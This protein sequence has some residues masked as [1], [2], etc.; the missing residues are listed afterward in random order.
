MKP[1]IRICVDR[2]GTFTDLI[3]FV[4]NSYN[5]KQPADGFHTIV[6]KLL[7][8]DS[9]YNDAPSEGIRRILELAL[10][11]KIPRNEPIPT[12]DIELI[13]MGTTV[14]TNALLERKGEKTLLL[15]TKGFQD[16]L[17]IGNQSRPNIF[18]L[19]VETMQVLYERVLE[20]DER[21]TPV[22]YTFNPKSMQVDVQ[23]ESKEY[24]KGITGQWLK[25]LQ[26]PDLNKLKIELL[27]A[28]K[29]GFES[30]AITFLHSYTLPI[31][32]EMVA[33]LCQQVGFK[34]ITMSSKTS[35][36]AKIVPRGT[37]TTADAYLTPVIQTYLNSFFKQFD[38]GIKTTKVEFMQ[39]DGGLVSASDFNGFKA[40][41]SGP[42]GGVVGYAA[43]SWQ[44]GGRAI[45]GFDMVI[46]LIGRNINRCVKVWRKFR[47]CF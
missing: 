35:S 17:K 10:N 27:K 42:A 7:S 39:S 44:H 16:L 43:T 13:R 33:E 30:V 11:L 3:A 28:K 29:D 8:V 15:I 46:N 14:A 4:P 18:D 9:A 40:I 41:L 26:Q 12:S 22:G 1:G 24:K 45:V 32:E 20:V 5:N 31:H 37:S 2:G 36:M 19:K 21:V 38:D 23:I 34:N 6:I 47:A 25:I